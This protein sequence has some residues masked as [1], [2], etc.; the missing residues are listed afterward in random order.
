MENTTPIE[1][2]GLDR[3][4]LQRFSLRDRHASA[5]AKLME[6]RDDLR[7]TYAFADMVDDSLRW[8]A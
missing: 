1:P 8:S 5:L 2:V 4:T 7:G 3:T 6:E